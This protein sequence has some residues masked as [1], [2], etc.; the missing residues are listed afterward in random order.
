MHT[1][2]RKKGWS[3][4]ELKRLHKAKTHA[5]T[6]R[7]AAVKFLDRYLF[8]LVVLAAV[9]VNFVVAVLLVPFLLVLSSLH[10]F[11]VVI[12]M[13]ICFGFLFENLLSDFAE[14]S[15]HHY[16]LI[17]GIVP[18]VAAVSVMVLSEF[19]NFLITFLN[20][21]NIQHHP[22]LIGLTYGLSFLFPFA[23]RHI[24]RP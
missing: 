13:G 19:A 3:E 18:S 22:L 20:L 9:V 4:K 7:S 16:I 6:H 21:S 24:L 8:W 17:V 11:V 1:R 10:L 14:L 23:I 12:I 15:H 2:L 5:Q